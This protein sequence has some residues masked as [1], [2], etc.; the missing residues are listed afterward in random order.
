MTLAMTKAKLLVIVAAAALAVLGLAACASGEAQAPTAPP[1]AGTAEAKPADSQLADAL[2]QS[3]QSYGNS[4]RSQGIWVEG[5]GEAAATPDLAILDLGVEAFAGTVAE[6]RRD[7]AAAMSRILEVIVARG[8]EDRDVQTRYFNID[9][10]YTTIEKAVCP[11]AAQPQPE[12]LPPQLPGSPVGDCVIERQRIILGYNLNNHVSVRVRDLES[13]GE[14]IDE[15][16]EAGGDLV[17]FQGVRFS[18]EDT[19][20]LNDLARAAAVEDLVAKARHIAGLSGVELGR[21]LHIR[22]SG[23]NFISQGARLESALMDSAAASTPVQAGELTVT[24]TLHAEFA[25]APGEQ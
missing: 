14:V 19:K 10:R 7:G 23:G 1:A 16:T 11:D 25:I 8:I 3:L 13:I 6:A 12:G 17:R 21:L 15:V 2:L 22:E 5:V 24:V 9:A 20:A 18:I 4:G